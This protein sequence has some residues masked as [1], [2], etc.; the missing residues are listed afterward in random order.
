M[1]VN[2]YSQDGKKVVTVVDEELI[3]DV[4]EEGSAQIDL[5]SDFYK[6][7]R[8]MNEDGL[9]RTIDDAYIISLVGEESIGFGN[10][11]D[12]VDQE[13]V[14]E[15]EGVPHAQIILVEGDDE[16]LGLGDPSF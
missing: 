8:K 15:V 1:I 14:I 10:K 12:L 7:G 9:R 3:G 13:S 11:Y 5:T 16:T 2:E 4:F 6:N